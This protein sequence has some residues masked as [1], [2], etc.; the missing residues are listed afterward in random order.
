MQQ[1]TEYKPTTKTDGYPGIT[2][3]RKENHFT[4]EWTAILTD[5][6][7]KIKTPVT[8]RTYGTNAKN[9]ACLWVNCSAKGIHTGAGGNA[10]GYGYHRPSASAYEAITKAGFKL[11]EAIDGRGDSAIE[12]GNQVTRSHTTQPFTQAQP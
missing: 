4:D 5:Q 10:G 3:N 8:L 6:D 2:E 9:Y 11:A 7:G 1:V 12:E